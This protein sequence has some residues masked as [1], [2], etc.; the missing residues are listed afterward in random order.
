MHFSHWGWSD[1]ENYSYS[2]V[3]YWFEQ[4]KTAVKRKNQQAKKH[5]M[6]GRSPSKRVI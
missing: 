3:L 4:I 5:S 1:F 6:N 2:E